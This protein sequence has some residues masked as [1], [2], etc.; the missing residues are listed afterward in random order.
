MCWLLALTTVTWAVEGDPGQQISN[1][2]T[3]TLME[4]G[5]DQQPTIT[6]N[7]DLSRGSVVGLWDVFSVS[8]TKGGDDYAGTQVRVK[9]ELAKGAAD[10][11]DLQYFET[12]DEAY[13]FRPL[14]FDND[15]IAW[16]G[17]SNGFPLID[18]TS[19]FR[20]TWK[21]AGE[22][23]FRL[24]IVE[25]DSGNEEVL[26][27][28][29]E[30]ITVSANR[31]AID[32]KWDDGESSEPLNLTYKL[33][34]AFPV[35]A[36]AALADG[37]THVDNVL[38]V[39]RVTKDTDEGDVPADDS[40]LSIT[41]TDGQALGYNSEGEYFFWGPESGFQFCSQEAPSCAVSPATTTFEVTVHNAEDYEVSAYAVQLKA[42][43]EG[44]LPPLPDGVPGS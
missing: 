5:D 12:F 17:P 36:T 3:A 7:N 42:S 23:T 27:E 25:Q 41:G 24:S 26:Q 19:R 2:L 35:A 31:N 4:E 20:V 14:P 6:V 21:E 37:L 15:G 39:I 38:Y 1:E 40:D 30:T 16:Y 18:D 34:E 8:T 13:E 44:P 9:I 43:P 22:Y 33:E 32:L 11:F 28:I 29:T 10:G